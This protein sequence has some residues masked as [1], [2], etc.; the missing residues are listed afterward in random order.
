MKTNVN[1]VL[2]EFSSLENYGFQRKGKRW[3]R[4]SNETIVLV[5]LQKCSWDNSYFLNFGVW[6][7]NAGDPPGPMRGALCHLETR[8]GSEIE[9]AL[10]LDYEMD[11]DERAS[12]LRTFIKEAVVPLADQ[13]KTLSGCVSVVGAGGGFRSLRDDAEQLLGLKDPKS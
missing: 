5:E 11:P 2:R 12:V 13:C 3:T 7:L 9:Y 1:I 6:L 10:T 4:R 8:L